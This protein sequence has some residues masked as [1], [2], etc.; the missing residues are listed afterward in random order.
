MGKNDLNDYGDA[1]KQTDTKR[2]VDIASQRR[3][4]LDKACIKDVQ[5]R[6]K[7]SLPVNVMDLGAG[8]GTLSLA[9]AK[10]GADVH[11]VDLNLSQ[12]RRQHSQSSDVKGRVLFL[13]KSFATLDASDFPSEGLD[14][15]YSQRSIHYIPY[16]QALETLKTCF[17]AMSSGGMIYLSAAGY[18]T[19]YGL[20]YP[21]RDRAVE[22]RFSALSVD[23]REKHGIEHKIVT[24][25]TAEFSELVER[26]G[27]QTDRVWASTFGNIKL[28]GRRP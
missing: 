7:K 25:T 19:E 16:H 2:G 11:M 1:F 14:V 27:F 26:A 21:H 22:D 23:M 6:V 17:N 28:I 8:Y 10:L 5:S 3:D 20:T 4:D 24:F 18:D 12:A 9:M 15:L 13:E